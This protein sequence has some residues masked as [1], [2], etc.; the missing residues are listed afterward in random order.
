M[1]SEGY[2]ETGDIKWVTNKNLIHQ[3][4]PMALKKQSWQNW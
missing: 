3:N 4:I 2:K 1:F